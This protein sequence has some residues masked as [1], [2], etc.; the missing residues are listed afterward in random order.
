M[1]MTTSFHTRRDNA[2]TQFYN[3]AK[4]KIGIQTV[5]NHMHHLVNKLGRDWDKPR[6]KDQLRVYLKQKFF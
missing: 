3:S 6:I 2:F 4:K 1:M 5:W